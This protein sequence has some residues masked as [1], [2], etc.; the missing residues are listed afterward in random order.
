VVGVPTVRRFLSL[1]YLLPLAVCGLIGLHLYLLHLDVSSGR[2]TYMKFGD[3]FIRKDLVTIGNIILIVRALL[4]L[5][6]F[7]FVDADN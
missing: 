5:L 4:M 6:V 2:V 7:L 1:H 3:R